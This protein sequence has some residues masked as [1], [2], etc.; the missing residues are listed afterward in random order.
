MYDQDSLKAVR[1]LYYNAKAIRC[2]TQTVRVQRPFCTRAI[3]KLFI[4]TIK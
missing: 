3:R 1:V 4:P 2:G